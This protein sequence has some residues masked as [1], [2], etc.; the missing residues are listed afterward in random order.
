VESLPEKNVTQ[1]LKALGDGDTRVRDEL[2]SVLLP[3]LRKIAGGR[4]WRERPN[5]TLQRT[6]LV[7]EAYI[8]LANQLEVAFESREHFFKLVSK[9][10]RQVL[11]DY[12]RARQSEKRGGGQDN[13]SL[14]EAIAQGADPNP[15]YILLHEALSKY[16]QS[17][18]RG[19]EIVELHYFGGLSNEEIAKILGTSPSTVKRE[20]RAALAWLRSE[21]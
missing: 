4:M 18:P 3:H 17:D 5:H 21:M 2:W 20:L 6:A 15:E 11:F 7:N 9:V 1:M 10:M 19:G 8:R 14:D 13:L 12:A 16:E